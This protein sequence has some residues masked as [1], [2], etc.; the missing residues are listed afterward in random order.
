[1]LNRLFIVAIGIVTFG[2]AQQFL[3][4]FDF[5]ISCRKKPEDYERR[6]TV[7]QK[8]IGMRLEASWLKIQSD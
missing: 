8:D 1:M 7:I 6:V 5:S 3:F 4:Q 2:N